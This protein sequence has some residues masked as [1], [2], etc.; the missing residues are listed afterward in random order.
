MFALVD[1]NNFFVS[2]ERLF[3]PLLKGLPVVV[4]SNNDGCI[5][6]RSEEAK[7]LGIPMGAPAFEYRSLFLEYGVK[8]LSSNYIF[9]GDM[10][11]RVMQTLK[12]F[13][14]PVEVYSIDEAF[15]S[16]KEA[17]SALGHAI[18]NKVLKWTGIPISVGI[19]PTKTLAKAANRI[20]KKSEGT[21][22]ITEANSDFFLKN[23]PVSEIWGIGRRLSRRLYAHGIRSAFEL[24]NCSDFWL[25]KELSV[26]GLRI[27]L[28]L[29]G[30]PSLECLEIAPKRKSIICTRS[31]GCPVSSLSELKEAL[32]TFTAH[33]ACKLRKE[34]LK[35]HHLLVFI[36]SSRFESASAY[37]SLPLPSSFTPELVEQAHRLLDSLFAEGTKYRRAGVQLGELVDEKATQLDFF[38]QEPKEKQNLMLAMDKINEKFNKQMVAFASDGTVKKWKGLSAHRTPHYTTSWNELL[39]VF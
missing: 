13:G 9:Y 16:L 3:D 32:S 28:E 24:K 35:A 8:V 10:S 17:D 23:F 38:T 27:A 1:C 34:R 4:L 26:T 31:F 21:L 30:I 18:R 15:I 36:S 33:A 5:I 19:A 2:C 11:K 6:A 14:F 37:F 20:A 39:S 7:A 25:K 29:R 22:V 12:T